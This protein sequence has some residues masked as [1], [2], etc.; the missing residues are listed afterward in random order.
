MI[1]ST[2]NKTPPPTFTYYERLIAHVAEI[3]LTNNRYITT[4]TVEF[5]SSESENSINLPVKHQNIFIAIKL[6]DPAASITI[7]DKVI[8]KSQELPIGTAYTESFDV[9]TDK[10]QIPPFL[11]SPRHSLHI[12][13]IRYEI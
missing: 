9:I 11:R 10:K 3:K 5:G 13:G 2:S 6:L 1:S 7:K 4:I 12:N 8:T